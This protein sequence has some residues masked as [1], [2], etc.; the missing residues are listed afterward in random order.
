MGDQTTMRW[1]TFA[2]IYRLPRGRAARA[3]WPCPILTES[4]EKRNIFFDLSG[5]ACSSPLVEVR[6]RYS[7]AASGPSKSTVSRLDGRRAF[8][9]VVACDVVMFCFFTCELPRWVTVWFSPLDRVKRRF[10][11]V[12]TYL[13]WTLAAGVGQAA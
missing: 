4:Q 7:K 10:C 1:C 13:K 11:E 9:T 12:S 6:K 8:L 5:D 3:V 2:H